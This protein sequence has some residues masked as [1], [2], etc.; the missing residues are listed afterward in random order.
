[1][2]HHSG[3][4]FFEAEEF[5]GQIRDDTR[6]EAGMLK[7]LH[8]V[9]NGL[10]N[11]GRELSRRLLQGYLNNCGD[12]D[13]GSKVITSTNLK[14][15]HKRLMPRSIQTFFGTVVLHR[16]GY[17]TRG[18]P[19]IYPMDAF[20]ELP[21]SS[22]SYPLQKFLINEVAKGSIEEALQLVYE[23]TGVTISKGKAM[24]LIQ[25]SAEDFDSFYQ[26]KGRPTTTRNCPLMVLTTD[27]KGIVMRPEGLRENTKKRRLLMENKPKTRRSKGEKRNAKRMAPVAS[28]Y[29]ID[30]FIRHPKDVFDECSRHQARL[31]RPK[32]VAKRLWASVEKDAA[33]VIDL[34]V[35]Q[36]VKRDPDQNK[37]WVV[38]ID[39][40]E[41]QIEQIKAALKRQQVQ[42]T[43]VLDIVHVIE[44]LWKA[45]HK[46]F[47]EGSWQCE[48]WVESKLQM[49]LEKGG[50]KTAGS[51][52]MSAA[53][54]LPKD[55]DEVVAKSAFEAK[56]FQRKTLASNISCQSSGLHQ[57]LRLPKKRLS[58]WHWGY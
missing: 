26:T 31:R 34:L 29:Y 53:K 22:V 51:I 52:R 18:H 32:P 4:G 38:L 54:S 5:F 33:E 17:S 44:Y 36:A 27:A 2:L 11:K 28:I 13:V 20:L 10:R 49:I 45:A 15:T 47:P 55:Q 57:L 43:I 42:A 39:G 56:V 21:L 14:L 12:G 35:V 23:I 41:Y 19:S 8:L 3:I 30:R 6:D 46:F 9:E 48:R 58:Y 50:R 1:M 16:V 7:S 40:Q 24:E 25:S 37:E